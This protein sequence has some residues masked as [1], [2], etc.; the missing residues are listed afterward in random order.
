MRNAFSAR[1]L[2]CLHNG[3]RGTNATGAYKRGQVNRGHR[4]EGP[5]GKRER[6]RGGSLAW[7][8]VALPC[9]A[10]PC[11]AV[12]AAV[13]VA[14]EGALLLT[15]C[16]WA[17]QRDKQSPRVECLRAEGPRT[18]NVSRRE[19]L[20]SH[21]SDSTRCAHGVAVGTSWAKGAQVASL[22]CV[23][24][25]CRLR[26]QELPTWIYKTSSACASACTTR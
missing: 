22:H 18:G 7:A 9:L 12:A 2:G 23:G 3:V 20:R 5:S 10:L 21:D 25:R 6:V 14:G 13:A 26:T 4:V 17:R 19:S 24:R 1:R 16:G 11:L 15:L 8:G